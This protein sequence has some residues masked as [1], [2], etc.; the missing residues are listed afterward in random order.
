MY[1][2]LCVGHG[3]PDLRQQ[4]PADAIAAH[5][6]SW[7]ATIDASVDVHGHGM[8]AVDGEA[9]ERGENVALGVHDATK[10]GNLAN[11]LELI[12]VDRFFA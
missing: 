4:I 1:R 9:A 2:G 3:C 10:L 5:I 8:R 7:D 11:P 6:V 12:D